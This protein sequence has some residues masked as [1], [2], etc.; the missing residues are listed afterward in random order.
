MRKFFA[1]MVTFMIAM[2]LVACSGDDEDKKKEETAQEANQEV[3][4]SEEEKV[5]QDEVVVEINGTEVKGDKYNAIY[6]QTKMQMHQFGEDADDLDA[7]KENTLDELIAQ[8]LLIQE[9]DKHGVKVS[10][11]RAKEE[12]E[13]AKSENEEQFNAYLEE[14]QLTEEMFTDQ[15]W[16]GLLVEKYMDEELQI[17]EVT[18]DEIQETYD[19]LKKESEEL[20]DFDELKEDLKKQLETQKKAEKLEAKLEK[21]KEDATIEKKI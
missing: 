19:E 7:V 13:T 1:F 5:D 6:P 17:D 18:N 10:K 4:I 2:V 15:I 11:D 20:P 12:M 21:L 14:F 8:E 9:A 16:L 3:E